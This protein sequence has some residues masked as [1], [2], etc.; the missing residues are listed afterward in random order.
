MKQAS[1]IIT[2]VNNRRS[3]GKLSGELVRRRLAACVNI[4]DIVRSVYKWKGKICKDK[5]CLLVIKTRA[6][7]AGTVST[8]LKSAHPYSVPEIAVIE[9]SKINDEYLRWLYSVTE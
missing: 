8:W 5:E 6:C 3:A 7:L 2:T 4:I 1:I 9:V